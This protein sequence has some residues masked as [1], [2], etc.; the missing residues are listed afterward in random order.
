MEKSNDL[1]PRAAAHK[2]GVSLYYIYQS[3]W[4]GK[5]AGRKIGKQWRIPAEAV[6]ARLKQRGE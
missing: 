6:N 2:L 3:L 1:T 5:L 4:A